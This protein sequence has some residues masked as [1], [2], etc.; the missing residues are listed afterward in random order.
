[1][2]TCVGLFSGRRKGVSGPPVPPR[3]TVPPPPRK[4]DIKLLLWTE[5]HPNPRM[6]TEEDLG[7]RRE[8]ALHCKKK[9]PLIKDPLSP[10]QWASVCFVYALRS[11]FCFH[12]I[13]DEYRY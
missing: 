12:C 8:L 11:S 1:M 9:L 10:G 2:T 6:E 13:A 7:P 3:V 5:S 4:V